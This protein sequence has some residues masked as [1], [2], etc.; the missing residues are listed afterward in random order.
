[1]LGASATPTLTLISSHEK[2]RNL[3]REKSGDDKDDSDTQISLARNEVES[4]W[5]LVEGLQQDECVHGV[6]VFSPFRGLHFRK[7][8][9]DFID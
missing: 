8:W 4:V 1:M 9:M 6:D 7:S 5:V 3:R 2:L